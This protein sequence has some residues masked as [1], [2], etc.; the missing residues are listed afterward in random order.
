MQCSCCADIFC[1]IQHRVSGIL[2]HTEYLVEFQTFCKIK[3]RDGKSFFEYGTVAVDIMHFF[4]A[5]F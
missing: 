3:G 1:L 4:A 2:E 5:G